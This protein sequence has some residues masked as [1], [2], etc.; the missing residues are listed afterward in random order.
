MKIQVARYEDCPFAGAVTFCTSG[1]SHPLLSQATRSPIRVEL[2]FSCYPRFGSWRPES[3]P[4][5]VAQSLLESH[6][7]PLQGGTVGPAGP[8][9]PG[10]S[11]DGFYYSSPWAFPDEFE[12]FR[13]EDGPVL[14]V[15]LVPVTSME[16][17]F[18]KQRGWLAFDALLE[19]KDPDLWDLERPSLVEAAE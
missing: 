9:K 17:R 7:A 5:M 14:F 11:L 6:Q 10:S 15:W 18:I 13:M 16:I 1:L 19:A 4:A 12:E 8:I 2:V 3:L